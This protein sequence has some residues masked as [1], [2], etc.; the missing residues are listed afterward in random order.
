M[1][2]V[3][4]YGC[5]HSTATQE[6]G[7]T[8]W[9]SVVPIPKYLGQSKIKWIHCTEMCYAQF[10][11]CKTFILIFFGGERSNWQCLHLAVLRKIN[12]NRFKL[13]ITV[14]SLT[15][16][17][18][19]MFNFSQDIKVMYMFQT[20]L[21]MFANVSFNVWPGFNFLLECFWWSFLLSHLSINV[22]VPTLFSALE[23]QPSS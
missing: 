4:Q 17:L 10:W 1:C 5:L 12:S 11:K 8:I 18:H 16:K 13:H 15:N 19:L 9:S 14:Y 20:L 21:N 7:P 23:V 6:T 2:T 22:H 3:K